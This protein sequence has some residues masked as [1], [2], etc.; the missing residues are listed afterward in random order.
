[1]ADPTNSQETSEAEE[2]AYTGPERRSG[3]DRR[4]S[5]DPKPPIG[6][7]ERRRWVRRRADRVA[8]EHA[9]RAGSTGAGGRLYQRVRIEVP[10]V[11]RPLREAAGAGGGSRRGLTYNLAPGGL[12]M[13]LDTEF[14]VGTI[15]EVLVRFEED[16]LAADVQ[17]V[18]VIPQR[19]LF[20][21]NCRFTRL[22]AAD[23]NWLTEYLRIRDRPHP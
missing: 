11:Y 19:N 12:G 23:R 5:H 18:S 2:E 3:L 10:V 14:S 7:V 9:R 13:L 16:L 1:M 4:Q 8:I 21:H 17:V 22:G 15:M 20:L 6:Q